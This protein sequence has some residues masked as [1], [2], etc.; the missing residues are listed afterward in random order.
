MLSFPKVLI[1]IE[2]VLIVVGVLW[3]V[4]GSFFPLGRLPGDVSVEKGNFKLYFPL[5][6]SLVVS[7]VLSFLF[8]I[9][10][11]IRK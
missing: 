5:A 9:F 11:L 10:Y 6:T 4:G 1:V 2:I 7:A 3:T 8:W